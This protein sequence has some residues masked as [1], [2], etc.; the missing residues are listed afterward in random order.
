VA[1]KTGPVMIEPGTNGH[2]EP[3]FAVPEPKASKAKVASTGNRKTI[4]IDSPN[5]IETSFEIV[6]L[7]PLVVHNW[8]IKAL[9]QMLG[10]RFGKVLEKNG[11]KDPEAEYRASRYI[12]TKRWDG[13][14]A[15]AFRAACV[16]ACRVLK[17]P[18]MTLAKTL[19]HILPD[20]ESIPIDIPELGLKFKPKPLVRIQGEPEMRTDMIRVDN[21]NP[22]VRFR[23][24]YWPWS[25]TLRVRFN[26]D[27]LSPNAMASLIYLAGTHQGIG[28]MRPSAPVNCTGENGQWA[29][30]KG[31]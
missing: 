16:G 4:D 22:D 20:G 28:E 12:S 15:G 3:R 21:G 26:S 17:E 7:T 31:K 27:V 6:G 29:L 30:K 18:S 19:F 14:P 9:A 11:V 5:I 8:D 2:T 24:E 13:F 23:A 25:A 1:R 10:P